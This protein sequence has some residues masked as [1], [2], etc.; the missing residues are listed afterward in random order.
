MVS[1]LGGEEKGSRACLEKTI[2][3]DTAVVVLL[4]LYPNVENN[5]SCLNGFEIWKTI[6]NCVQKCLLTFFILKHKKTTVQTKN[7]HYRGF[8]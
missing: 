1:L 8:L 6:E 2:K 5:S 4:E 7:K 3:K